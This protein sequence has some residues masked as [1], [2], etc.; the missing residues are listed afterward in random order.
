[1]ALAIDRQAIVDAVLEGVG[2]FNPPVPAA[3]KDGPNSHSG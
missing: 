3:L 1:M 2:V